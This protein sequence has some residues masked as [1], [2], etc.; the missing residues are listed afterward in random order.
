MKKLIKKYPYDLIIICFLF[1]LVITLSILFPYPY[2]RMI[3][4]IKNL[5]ES[6]YCYFLN[7]IHAENI[8]LPTNFFDLKIG[9]A[10]V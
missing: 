4:S 1:T 10:H 6:L 3:F 2:K 7:C 8:K 5:F 9:R